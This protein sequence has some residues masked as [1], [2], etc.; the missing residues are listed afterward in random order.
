[1][2]GKKGIRDGGGLHR[3]SM[4]RTKEVSIVTLRDLRQVYKGVP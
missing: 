1:L 4:A 2:A 3:R